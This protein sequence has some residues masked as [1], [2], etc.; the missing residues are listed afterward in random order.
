M[1]AQNPKSGCQTS[2]S[3]VKISIWH[4][5]REE[6]HRWEANCKVQRSFHAHDGLR[7]ANCKSKIQSLDME[8]AVANLKVENSTCKVQGEDSELKGLI[9]EGNTWACKQASQR[10]AR[11]LDRHPTL[12]T[13]LGWTYRHRF[14]VTTAGTRH[15][16]QTCRYTGHAAASGAKASGE[17]RKRKLQQSKY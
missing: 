8:V 1:R 17:S 9:G 16:K 13:S 3:K 7:S 11:V 6:P 12:D 4:V 2:K 10:C 15:V 5:E 14:A